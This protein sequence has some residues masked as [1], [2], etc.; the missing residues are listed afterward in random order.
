VATGAVD[1]FG[2][3]ILLVWLLGGIGGAA[4]VFGRRDLA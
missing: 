3:G 1:A 2:V 4:W